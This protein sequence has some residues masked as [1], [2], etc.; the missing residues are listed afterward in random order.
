MYRIFFLA[1]IIVCFSCA[2][3]EQTSLPPPMIDGTIEDFERLGVK[4][5]QLE[6]NVRLFFYQ[7][8]HYVWI[9][10]D[11]LEGSYATL[12]LRLVSEALPDTI[13]LHLSG[14]LGEWMV[15]EGAPRPDSPQSD[16]WWNMK[17]WYANEVWPNGMDGTNEKPR[18][19]FK[20]SKAREMQ[21]SK[22][23][24]GTGDWYLHFAMGSILKDDGSYTRVT[25]P[26]DGSFFRYG[27]D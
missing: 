24:F 26:G 20:L 7:D 25:F 18:Y 10:Y 3:T 27:V 4:P 15:T 12:D 8:R 19:N 13:N 5:I 23:R 9:A 22:E 14:Q 2:Q 16:L 11:Y 1:L 17:G 21:L 6:E